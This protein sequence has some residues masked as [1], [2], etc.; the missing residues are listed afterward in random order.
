M[1]AP[2]RETSRDQGER[3]HSPRKARGAIVRDSNGRRRSSDPVDH[4]DD[5]AEAGEHRGG[6]PEVPQPMIDC[7]LEHQPEHHDRNRADDHQPTQP[8][9]RIVAR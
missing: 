1:V 5:D 3:L 4:R 8:G 6:R 7:V 9:L 2:D